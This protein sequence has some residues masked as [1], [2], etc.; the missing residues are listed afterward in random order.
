MKRLIDYHLVKWKDSAHRKPLIIRGARQVGKTYAVR[1]LGDLFPTMIEINFELLPQARSIFQKDLQPKRILQEIS[2]LTGKKIIPGKTLLFFDE[3]QEAPEAIKALRYFYE[4][5]PQLHVI[6]AG[7]L[8]EFILEKIGLPVGRITSLYLYP[9]SFIEFLNATNHSNLIEPILKK[10]KLGEV[11]HQKLL[12]ILGLYLSVGG[13]PEAVLRFDELHSCQEVHQQ[14]V[15]TYRQDFQKYAKKHQIK[16]IELLSSHIPI[17]IGKLFKYSS[18]S[19]DY[20]KRELEPCLEL[21]ASAN[22]IHKVIH[23]AG[24]GLPIGAEINPKWIKLIYL[25]IA[26][27]QTILGT[28]LANWILNTEQQFINQGHIVEAFVGQELLCYGNPAMHQDLYFWKRE[29]RGSDAEIDYLIDHEGFVVP[30]EVKSG[31]GSSLKSLQIFLDSHPKSQFGIRFWSQGFASADKIESRP[32][33]SV[34]TLAH[35]DQLSA[36]DFLLDE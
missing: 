12:T 9:L 35:K 28:N 3:I 4:I 36:V 15:E 11:I 2:L 27:C 14:L 6:A 23:S 16:Y 29:K 22:V 1:K 24:N 31:K 8:L 10:Q 26:L 34:I 7:S 30:I 33:Y 25:D 21:L 19:A 5:F 18:I 20:K 32:L 13:M 17:L